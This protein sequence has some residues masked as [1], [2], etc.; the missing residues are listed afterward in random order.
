ML[1]GRYCVGEWHDQ[2]NNF[3][4]IAL[5]LLPIWARLLEIIALLRKT[6]EQ[7]KNVH[8]NP[9]LNKLYFYII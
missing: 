8:S 9:S 6:L 5:N 3:F 7:L 4:F 2:E 1:E